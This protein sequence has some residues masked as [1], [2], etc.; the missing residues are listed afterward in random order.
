MNANRL[1]PILCIVV[2]LPF[3]LLPVH[4]AA[5]VLDF[6]SLPGMSFSH[7]T[8]IPAV[9]KLSDEYLHT[10]GV[11]FSS[12]SPFI[13][14]VALG[15]GHAT[16]GI[17]GIGGSTSEGLLSYESPILATFFDPNNPFT[18]A[19]TDFVSVRGDLWGL[20]IT[21]TVTMT[22]YDVH[23]NQIGSYSA[24][25]TGGETLTVSV[26]GI[27]SV[28]L[29][30]SIAS[31]GVAYDDFTFNAVSPVP[32]PTTMLLLASGLIGLVGFRRKFRK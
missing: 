6:D 10:Y 2:S 32:E 15:A 20:G 4:G 31:G 9:S 25:D 3:I 13:A 28:R 26:P 27:H 18:P 1:S 5:I 29:S 22:A 12:G 16:S 17:N 24:L 11:E 14:V 7:G 19:A 8:P 21:Q 23:G 30:G